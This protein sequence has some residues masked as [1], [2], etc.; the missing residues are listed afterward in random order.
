MPPAGVVTGYG[1]GNG[2]AH[3]VPF[4]ASNSRPTL[5]DVSVMFPLSHAG[6]R[7]MKPTVGLT[8]FFLKINLCEKKP[9]SI[10]ASAGFS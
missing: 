5:H 9:V 2:N 6:A 8:A 1:K 10:N 4:L 3:G 7:K